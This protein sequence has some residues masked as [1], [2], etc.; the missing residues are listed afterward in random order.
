MENNQEQL[1]DSSEELLHFSEMKQKKI[2]TIRKNFLAWKQF[3]E[4]GKVIEQNQPT[5]MELEGF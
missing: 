1:Q 5:Y 3:R 2:E 4:S